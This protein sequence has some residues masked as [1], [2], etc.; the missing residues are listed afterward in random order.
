M[1]GLTHVASSADGTKIVAVSVAGY[2][3][4]STDSGATWT[5]R[6]TQ[7][8]LRGAASSADGTKLVAAG[9]SS[10]Y[11]STDSGVTWI[12]QPTSP[13]LS[14]VASSAD[15]T[16]LVGVGP[17]YHDYIYTSSGPVR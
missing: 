9:D 1:Q 8:Y 7:Y 6:G 13:A 2:L 17:G 16:K 14:Q 5:E 10:V 3:Y 4:T 12:E 15:G 11:T